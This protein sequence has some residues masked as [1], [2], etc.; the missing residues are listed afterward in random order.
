[1]KRIL[2]L[3]CILLCLFTSC[4]EPYTATD[5]L[6]KIMSL[7]IKRDAVICFYGADEEG[8]GY[9][10]NEKS[11]LLYSNQ[12]PMAMAE[13]FAIALGKDDAV[14]E[15]HLYHAL[16]GEKADAIELILQKRQ[17]LLLRKDN[18]LYTSES[19]ANATVWREGRWVALLATDD[20]ESVKQLLK[21]LI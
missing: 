13:D 16:D 10:S 12:D 11:S 4:G 21:K 18:E 9:L 19:Y 6:A 8:E 15:V 17:S 5:L 20:N 3:V 2:P 7:P 1:M 14:F